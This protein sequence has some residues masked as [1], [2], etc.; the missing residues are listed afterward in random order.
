MYY[1]Q[2]ASYVYFILKKKNLIVGI[3]IPKTQMKRPSDLSNQPYYSKW[4]R[5]KNLG[6]Q[7][8]YPGLGAWLK[9]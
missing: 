3:I 6:L 5:D 2:Y 1:L 7:T 8:P 4:H 9:G